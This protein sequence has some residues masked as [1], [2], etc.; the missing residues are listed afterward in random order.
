MRKQLPDELWYKDY[1]GKKIIAPAYKRI[2]QVPLHLPKN[3]AEPWELAV[4]EPLPIEINEDFRLEGSKYWD[5]IAISTEHYNEHGY[6]L[7]RAECKILLDRTRAEKTAYNLFEDK[8]Q[9]V[10]L[11]NQLDDQEDKV[12]FTRT[13]IKPIL[14]KWLKI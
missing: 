6:F 12:E 1:M 8:D 10:K 7:N 11:L 2:Y 14:Q 5:Y 4:Q 13:F 9:L 3:W